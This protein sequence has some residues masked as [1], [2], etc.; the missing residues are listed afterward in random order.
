MIAVTLGA[1]SSRGYRTGRGG[2]Y[3][4][5]HG[6]PG[7]VYILRNEGLKAGYF[8]IGCS[9]RS[10]HK[11]AFELN[12]DANTGTPGTFR[13]VFEQRTKDCGRAEQLVFQRLH[14][15]RR[16]KRGQEFFEVELEVA[17]RTIGAVCGEID[18]AH[19]PVSFPL[20]ARSEFP[21][22]SPGDTPPLTGPNPAAG[23]GAL[24]VSAILLA[25]L[26]V[27]IALAKDGPSR[28]ERSASVEHGAG[29]VSE[30]RPRSQQPRLPAAKSLKPLVQAPASASA[31]ASVQQIAPSEP[32]HVPD[33]RKNPD[34]SGLSRDE[35]ES[36]EAV[37]STSKHLRL[38]SAYE[39]C[40]V[41]SLGELERIPPV[42]LSGFSKGDV[43]LLRSLCSTEKALKGPAAY[44]ACL[45]RRALSLP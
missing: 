30:P 10:G 26:I 9:R 3:D 41:W 33:A 23:K 39:D 38:P 44:R 32:L 25:L 18:A 16:G 11:R 37:C 45:A 1:M 42:D 2:D 8:K 21:D 24:W 5:N 43:E 13:C 34:L 4:Q 17:R 28:V 19:V 29:S 15:H 31:E 6:V 14:A 12:V 7:V 20:S 35:R 22:C 40:L 27:W 36:T